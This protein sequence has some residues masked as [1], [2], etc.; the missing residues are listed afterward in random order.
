MRATRVSGG[1]SA[2]THP[3]SWAQRA[4]EE[5]LAHAGRGVPRALSPCSSPACPVYFQGV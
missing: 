5:V 3:H 4:G 1:W 2:P